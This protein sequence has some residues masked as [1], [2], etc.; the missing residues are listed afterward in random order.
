MKKE[1]TVGMDMLHGPMLKNILLFALPLAAGSILQQLFNAVD[2]AVVGQFA[3]SQ[4]LAAVGANSSVVTLFINF[5]T[6]ISVG[7]NVV[8]AHMIGKGEED[9]ISGAVHTSIVFSLLSGLVMLVAGILIARPLLTLMSTPD[10]IMDMAVLYLRIYCVG[11]PFILLYN[12]AA[13]ILRSIGDTRRPLYC[14]VTAGVLNACLNLFFVIVLHMGVSGVAIAT[15]I[16][17]VVNSGMAVWFLCHSDS[18]VRLELKKLRIQKRELMLILKIGVPSGIQGMVFSIANVCIQSSINSFGSDAVAGSTVAQNFE[19]MS[20]FLVSGFNSAAVTFVSQNYGAGNLKRCKKAFLLSLALAAVIDFAVDSSFYLG[21]NTLIG[22][23]TTDAAVIPYAVLR[24]RYV[25][26]PHVMISSYEISG[27][28]LRGLGHSLLP[29]VLMIF[30]TC[31]FRLIYINTV[32]PAYHEFSVLML[33]Y[34]LSWLI[35]GTLV[36]AAFVVVWRKIVGSATV[37]D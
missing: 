31:V 35:T 37:V 23:F 22:F 3:S 29:S 17:N 18:T 21:R 32:V 30:G 28:A 36:V 27:S 25:V 16:S 20:Y 24:L 34:P 7:S 4:A 19:Y 5:F 14:L 10:N 11:M 6:G 2:V 1:T 26:L 13:A 12:F 8:I 33:V 15:V 9:Q